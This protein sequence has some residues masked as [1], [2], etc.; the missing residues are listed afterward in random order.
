MRFLMSAVIGLIVLS[1]VF[2]GPALGVPACSQVTADWC[3]TNE[4]CPYSY[5]A[6]QGSCEQS[7]R[8]WKCVWENINHEPCGEGPWIGCNCPG[9]GGGCDCLLAGTPISMADGSTK[10]V[11]KIRAGDEVLG[12]DEA[13]RSLIKTKVRAVMTPFKTDNYYIINGK[14]RITESHPILR[15]ANWTEAGSLKVGDV[16]AGDGSGLSIFRIQKV[17]EEALV[18]NFEVENGTYLAAGFIVHNKEFCTY[19]HQDPPSR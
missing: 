7:N 10:P 3:L 1:A 12:Y 14:L 17:D 18:Y 6:W 13:T 2:T 4:A 11:E 16:V 19:F 9:Q 5:I 15:G 8:Q